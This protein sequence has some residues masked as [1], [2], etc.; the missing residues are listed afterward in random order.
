[1]H[2]VARRGGEVLHGRQGGVAQVA[3]GRREGA[4]APEPHP[5]PVAPA[6]DPL[7][8]SPG[9]EL[10][11]DAVR[12]GRGQRGRGDDVGE[13]ELGG[14]VGERGEYSE[15]PA[16]H[17]AGRILRDRFCEVGHRPGCPGQ[18]SRHTRRVAVTPGGRVL[19]AWSDDEGCGASPRGRFG[20]RRDSREARDVGRTVRR[21]VPAHGSA[22]RPGP[23]VGRR[24]A[25]PTGA[26]P[27]C[28]PAATSRSPPRSRR[29]APRRSSRCATRRAAS[30]R[31]PRR[32]T[33]AR[34]SR[35]TAAGCCSSTSTRRARCRWAS[36]SSRTSSTPRSTT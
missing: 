2:D 7:Q 5:D 22:A 23:S 34:P 6:P 35:S 31:R 11:D 33:S 1:M 8:G 18:R 17:R 9:D 12:R 10:G 30:G 27:P 28:G 16:Q 15:C 19:L 3:G 29:T 13:G 20:P 36:A 25:G 32:S 14:G 24:A 21:R 26:I 4:D